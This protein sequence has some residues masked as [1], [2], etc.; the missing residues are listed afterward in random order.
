VMG[1]LAVLSCRPL[2]L[3]GWNAHLPSA[4][5]C[6]MCGSASAPTQSDP[7]PVVF[8]SCPPPS[9]PVIPLRPSSC[10]RALSRRL[11]IPPASTPT[12][13]LGQSSSK[14]GGPP[15]PRTIVAESW[16]C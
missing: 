3:P 2:P 12:S 16:R 14:A 13:T 1:P 11:C 9:A 8:Y 5:A 15:I 7:S 4:R 10:P 6:C